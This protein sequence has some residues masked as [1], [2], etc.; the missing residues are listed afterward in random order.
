MVFFLVITSLYLLSISGSQ[1]VL[2]QTS[3]AYSK[4][5]R[6][7]FDSLD[8]RRPRHL[9]LLIAGDSVSRYQYLS[10]IYYLRHG[11]FWLD[12]T[13]KT[14]NKSIVCEREFENWPSFF[15]G[16]KYGSTTL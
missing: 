13:H 2:Y 9:R 16:N 12:D 5:N 7:R 15:S 8:E 11:V 4:K 10:L 14:I 3:K 6:G 1:M